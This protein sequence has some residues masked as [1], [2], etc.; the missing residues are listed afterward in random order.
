MSEVLERLVAEIPSDLKGLVDADPRDNKEVVIAALWREFGGKRKGVL[1]RRI[2]E[3]KRRLSIIESERNERQREL[4]ETKQELENLQERYEAAKSEEARE[5]E[6]LTQACEA[7]EGVN[8]T[9][10]HQQVQFLA[11]ELGI[12]KE[13]LIQEVEARRNQ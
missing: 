13:T 1:E 11:K 7:L 6:Q 5:E 10:E 8:L 12:T 2:E 3:K 4:T 9:P